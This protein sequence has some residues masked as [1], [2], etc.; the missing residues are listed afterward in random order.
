MES[1]HDNHGHSFAADLNAMWQLNTRRRQSLLWMLVGA[2]AL[3]MLGCGVSAANRIKTSPFTF[4]LAALNEVHATSGYSASVRI[5]AQISYATDK[6]FSDGSTLQMASVTGNPS[7]GYG[8][9][10]TVGVAG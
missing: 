6:V 8:V 10:L 7:D 9:T 3:P 2:S 4:P 1:H 5:L